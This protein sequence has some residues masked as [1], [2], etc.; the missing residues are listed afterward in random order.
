MPTRRISWLG[1]AKAVL[2]LAAVLSVPC[3]LN[4]GPFLLRNT[5]TNGS[6]TPQL[7]SEASL[8]ATGAARS[9]MA[10]GRPALKNGSGTDA[11][12][13]S[14][15]ATPMARESGP[16]LQVSLEFVPSKTPGSDERTVGV[17]LYKAAD[18]RRT[19]RAASSDLSRYETIDGT[20]RPE[21]HEEILAGGRYSRRDIEFR[22]GYA[23]LMSDDP[24]A[25]MPEPSTFA[26]LGLGLLFLWKRGVRGRRS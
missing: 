15:G 9:T 14:F 24:G 13:T 8:T 3:S 10:I 1:I 12:L 7:S 17:V 20:L 4:A 18:T 11:V 6:R 26:L 22:N 21:K 25:N 23:P 19:Q 5:F 16:S 2:G